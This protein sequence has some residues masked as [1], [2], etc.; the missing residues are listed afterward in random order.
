MDHKPPRALLS[1]GKMPE[2]LPSPPGHL[3]SCRR[4]ENPRLP[5]EP[6]FFFFCSPSLLA[7]V[8]P[9]DSSP[10][11][12]PSHGPKSPHQPSSCVLVQICQ[13]PSM[14]IISP[15]PLLF[16]STI[17]RALSSF[18]IANHHHP[19]LPRRRSSPDQVAV[20]SLFSKPLLFRSST[21][22][23]CNVLLSAKK[24]NHR[25]FHGKFLTRLSIQSPHDTRDNHFANLH[26]VC[27]P[28]PQ[29]S[30]P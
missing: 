16:H 7:D 25:Y 28:P 10:S 13:S 20:A 18:R 24:T 14:A 9:W 26:D 30:H 6:L 2:L 21:T 1:L 19:M 22:M 17:H 27:H 23:S 29:G 3:R 12:S 4:L 15:P 11:T 5:S 8:F